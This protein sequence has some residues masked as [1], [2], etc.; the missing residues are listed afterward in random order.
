MRAFLIRL[1][2]SMIFQNIATFIV[3]LLLVVTPLAV[4][5]LNDVEELVSDTIREK[6]GAVAELGTFMLDGEE[7]SSL[8]NMIWYDTPEYERTIETLATI[9][10]NFDVD[11]AV[12]YRRM[13]G[14]QFVYVGDG[15]RVFPIGAPVELHRSF[16]ETYAPAAK[17]WD[18]GQRG[19]TRLFESGG[20]AW[21]QINTPIKVGDKVVAVLMLNKFATPVAAA[22]NERQR[23]IL[24]GFSL[25]LGGGVLVWWLLTTLALRPLIRLKRASE[26][27]A[28]GNLDVQVPYTTNRSEIGSL[29]WSFITMVAELRENRARI[30]EHS[31]TLEARIE[32][33]T[34]EIRTLQ[35]NMEEGLFAMDATGLILPGY[36]KATE[37][38][39]GKLNGASN[40]INM[41]SDDEVLRKTMR[42][43]FD[44]LMNSAMSLPW[45]DM[46]ANLP[47][48]FQPDGERYLH[49]RY[50]AVRDATGERIERVM[51]VLKDISTQKALEGDIEQ[52]RQLHDMVVKI[53]Q[54][55][56]TFD[57]FYEDANALLN[58]AARTLAMMD[59]LR[60]SEVDRV[61]RAMHTIKGTAALFGM[62]E[63]SARAHEIEDTLRD[64]GG[65]RDE[66][67]A[68]AEREGFRAEIQALQQL[69]ADTRANFLRIVGE[70]DGE[71]TFSL[72]ASKLENVQR[73]V[74]ERVPPETH[75]AVRM[76]LLRLKRIPT[77]RL[78]R[79]YKS[80]V[81]SLGAKLGKQVEFVLDEQEETEIPVDYFKKL[82]PTFLH[83][84]RN[85]M[86]HGVEEPEYRMEAGKDARSTIRLAVAHKA[87]GIVFT[88]SD[89]G[90][91][92]DPE[93]IKA[94][95]LERGF[96]TPERARDL[97]AEGLLRLLFTPSFS[98][99]QEVTELS[100][101]GV[102]LDVVRTDVEALGG[103]LRF[104]TRVGM[105]T[106]F[107]LYYPLPA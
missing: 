89:D 23:T 45:E 65:R 98:S 58:D 68:D 100:G 21:F 91:G 62:N 32:E 29:I 12:L 8:R 88:L 73:Q 55:R 56:E 99:K 48:E 82:D 20:S 2:S 50:R 94:V 57:L 10:R 93:R 102:G 95:A 87:D 84:I 26:E 78:L 64:F 90:R 46:T 13:E 79:K 42:D 77:S 51:V 103:R 5:Y 101:R 75:D 40:F 24:I 83:L 85:S 72:T 59:L 92:V 71:S 27:I 43:T 11:N 104:S 53:L 96:L 38:M 41:L 36:S 86:D 107:Q 76:V 61:F 31:Q 7:A 16:P 1:V 66:A 97:D 14:G 80:L 28:Q 37:T 54:N 52:S 70:E 25:A 67:L 34:R 9:Q 17:A 44:L 3:I 105:G 69:M 30:E 106:T 15:N 22:I 47:A 49:A 35:D 19:G 18:S 4:R 39:L 63:V 33:R 74:L 81:E 6:L 60:R